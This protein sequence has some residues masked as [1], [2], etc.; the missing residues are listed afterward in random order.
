MPSITL[1]A[2]HLMRPADFD[3][4]YTLL[5][6]KSNEGSPEPLHLIWWGIAFK[7]YSGRR[8]HY[9]GFTNEEPIAVTM[10]L[11]LKREFWV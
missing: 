7:E 1:A 10:C 2:K 8:L 5:L 6:L 4:A 9:Q 11:P 3:V